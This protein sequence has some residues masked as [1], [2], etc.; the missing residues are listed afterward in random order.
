MSSSSAKSADPVFL[1][2]A[3]VLSSSYPSQPASRSSSL[4]SVDASAL[5]G[6]PEPEQAVDLTSSAE[7]SDQM[8]KE[9]RSSSMSSN[10]SA[11]RRFLKLGPVHG[12]DQPQQDFVEV[13]EE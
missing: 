5:A 8:V 4:S 11:R 2:L 12:G 7:P 9:R 6:Q 13:D 3:P 1:S 10:S